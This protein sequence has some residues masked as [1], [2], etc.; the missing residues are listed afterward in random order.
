MVPLVMTMSLWLLVVQVQAN[1]N[2]WWTYEGISGHNY[3]IINKAWFMCSKGKAQ[4]PI[5]L[6]PGKVVFDP[7]LTS[8]NVDKA[9]IKTSVLYNTGQVLAL[10]VPPPSKDRLVS[11]KIRNSS[12]SLTTSITGGPLSYRYLWR[13]ALIESGLLLPKS[14]RNSISQQLVAYQS[15]TSAKQALHSGHFEAQVSSAHTH[16]ATL[17]NL[18]ANRRGGFITIPEVTLLLS[19]IWRDLEIGPSNRC[20]SKPSK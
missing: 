6:D 3:W 20:Q 8:V 15:L 11:R 14:T 1:W 9:Q 16:M 10:K 19:R 7:T 5:D 12:S 17:S 2:T 13:L 4:S 18:E